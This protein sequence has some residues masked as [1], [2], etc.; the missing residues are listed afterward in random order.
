FR[1]W[2]Q[3]PRGNGTWY[4]TGTAVTAAPSTGRGE[5]ALGLFW[6]KSFGTTFTPVP[7]N[8]FVPI[9]HILP[10]IPFLPQIAQHGSITVRGEG[11]EGGSGGGR[12]TAPYCLCTAAHEEDYRL[13]R[14]GGINKAAF[15]LFGRRKPC[16][17]VPAIFSARSRGEASQPGGTVPALLRSKTH[18]GL[19]ESGSVLEG[20]GANPAGEELQV[21]ATRS[22]VTKCDGPE[23][24][25]LPAAGP[26]M[27]PSV[28]RLCSMFTDVTSLKSFDSLTGCGDIIAD[29][30]DEGG[31][32]G[33]S[34]TSSGTGSSSGGGA[35]GGPDGRQVAHGAHE[36]PEVHKAGA[37]AGG[38][39]S[40]GQVRAPPSASSAAPAPLTTAAIPAIFRGHVDAPKVQGSGVVAYMGGG[41][42]MAS[43]EEMDDADMQDLWHMLPR[44]NEATPPRP[45]GPRPEK[46]PQGALASGPP[47]A[48]P[49]RTELPRTKIPVSKVPVRRTSNNPAGAHRK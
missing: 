36:S 16:G 12:Q 14:G 9:G 11:G 35:A 49:P 32:S 17:A 10:L 18:D 41:E 40:A 38:G 22:A 25:P 7:L 46:R 13:L 23:A 4:I 43:P 8:P 37:P 42:E 29:A 39:A 15:K 24:R 45:K 6:D 34:G 19:A 2:R 48:P 47:R 26:I 1:S 21:Q 33:G 3:T 31:G 20:G 28:D 27:T 44:S 5:E 30:E